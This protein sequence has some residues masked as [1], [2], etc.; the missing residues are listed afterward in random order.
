MQATEWATDK[1]WQAVQQHGRLALK[2]KKKPPGRTLNETTLQ[3][4]EM[5]GSGNPETLFISSADG[6]F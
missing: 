4:F 6:I 2:K 3:C 1:S 5:S